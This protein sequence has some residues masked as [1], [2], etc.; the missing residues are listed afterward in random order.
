[1]F[2][3]KLFEQ[4]SQLQNQG[5]TGV[6]FSNE[7]KIDPNHQ[8]LSYIPL[9]GTTF[10]RKTMLANKIQ[11]IPREFAN[12]ELELEGEPPQPLAR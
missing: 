6:K 2:Y 9:K 5:T 7:Y 11:Y 10:K 3:F 12:M 4:K 1:M 8:D